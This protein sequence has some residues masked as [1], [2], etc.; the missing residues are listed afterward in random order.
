M[1]RFPLTPS[2][3]LKLSRRLYAHVPAAEIGDYRLIYGLAA[4][5]RLL[6]IPISRHDILPL[7]ALFKIA[8]YSP[9]GIHSLYA[10]EHDAPILRHHSPH[11]HCIEISFHQIYLYRIFSLSHCLYMFHHHS[12]SQRL[13]KFD[14]SFQC[15]AWYY[16]LLFCQE[17]SHA[18]QALS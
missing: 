7:N 5:A 10:A 13:D 1:P 18:T 15:H 2:L 17:F 6:T 11:Y 4:K 12:V 8:S 3:A 9:P 14:S 16:V